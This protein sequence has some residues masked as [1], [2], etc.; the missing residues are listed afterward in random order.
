MRYRYELAVVMA[1]LVLAGCGDGDTVTPVTVT[2]SSL[3]TTSTTTTTTTTTVPPLPEIPLES[4][5]V[6]PLAELDEDHGG[7]LLVETYCQSNPAG[8]GDDVGLVDPNLQAMFAF[9]GVEHDTVD[10]DM[11]VGIDLEAERYSAQYTGPAGVCFTGF[12]LQGEIS[13]SVGDQEW[14]WDVDVHKEP[15]GWITGCDDDEESSDSPLPWSVRTAPFHEP[16]QEF[17]G[18]LGDLAFAAGG[19]GAIPVGDTPP[20]PEIYEVLAA[21]LHSGS[22][23][24]RCR[25]VD[26]IKSLAF[27]IFRLQESEEISSDH[28]LWGL[29]PHLLYTYVELEESGRLEQDCFSDFESALGNVTQEDHRFVRDWAEWWV[30]EYAG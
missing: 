10:C 21:S 18:P 13:V 20:D 12:T 9:M 28:P 5:P 27:D 11:V 1:V 26:I 14:S 2:G 22:V 6:M 23:D 25:T 16:L 8:A 15:P 24:N 3:T 19:L 30:E 17:F 29:V 7:P 4:I